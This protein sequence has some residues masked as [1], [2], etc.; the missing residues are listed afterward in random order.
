[1]GSKSKVQIYTQRAIYAK[2]AEEKL[3]A[4]ANAIYEV[5]D[6]IDDLE[7]KLNSIERQIKR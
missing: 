1:M 7:N 4:L 5:A 2:T 6:F 3:N